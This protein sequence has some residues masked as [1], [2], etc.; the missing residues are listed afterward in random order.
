LVGVG[1][2]GEQKIVGL[3]T[4]FFFQQMDTCPNERNQK[5]SLL[6]LRIPLELVVTKKRDAKI[7]SQVQLQSYAG[8]SLTFA[9]YDTR[10]R[11]VTLEAA[12]TEQKQE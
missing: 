2:E 12:M 5:S 6:S 8:E 9:L 3:D 11:T 7:Y 1:L 4:L 10:L